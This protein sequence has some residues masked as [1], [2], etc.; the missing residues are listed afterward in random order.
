[1]LSQRVRGRPEGKM[2]EMVAKASPL[3]LIRH[4]EYEPGD[5]TVV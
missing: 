5:W 2:Q 4:N 1:M 3:S